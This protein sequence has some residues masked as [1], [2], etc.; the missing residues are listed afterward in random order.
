MTLYCVTCG[1]QLV[2]DQRVACSRECAGHMAGAAPGVTKYD[3]DVK[4][5]IA[6]RWRDGV[7][8]SAIGVEFDM[9]K[10]AVIGLV[11]R[12]G[13]PA[14]SSPI[15][16]KPDGAPRKRTTI[17]RAPAITLPKPSSITKE[18]DQP[19]LDQPHV[20]STLHCQYPFG[21]PKAP[22]FRFCGEPVLVGSSYCVECRKVCYSR[23]PMHEAA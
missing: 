17:K 12:M 19:A 22:D 16:F 10:N 3:P 23:V 13:L 18:V 7:V 4:R 11:H 15:G 5:L 9:T 1:K 2:H 8:A 20:S 6:Q 21:D 14:R